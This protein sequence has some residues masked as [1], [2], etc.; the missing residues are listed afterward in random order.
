ME[1]MFDQVAALVIGK[2]EALADKLPA[3]G[4]D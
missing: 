3:T 1:K 2:V 4:G